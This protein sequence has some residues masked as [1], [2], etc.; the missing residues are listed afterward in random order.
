M[1]GIFN[2]DGM[3]GVGILIIKRTVDEGD[4]EEVEKNAYFFGNCLYPITLTIRNMADAL[5]KP[6]TSLDFFAMTFFL[7]V[8]VFSGFF[9]IGKIN[10]IVLRNDLTTTI[11]NVGKSKRC[12]IQ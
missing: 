3:V 4:I 9:F 5:I 2:T 1:I 8:F 7:R 11:P 6:I 10:C 12:G